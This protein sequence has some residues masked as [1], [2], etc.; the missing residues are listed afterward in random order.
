MSLSLGTTT[1]VFQSLNAHGDVL[2][3]GIL[4]WYLERIG[5]RALWDITNTGCSSPSYG[6]NLYTSSYICGALARPL[7][8][9]IQH[10]RQAQ[11]AM[12]WEQ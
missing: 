11:G 12:L 2:T 4:P 3:N 1:D 5:A 10:G 9:P 7:N 6:K 8:T